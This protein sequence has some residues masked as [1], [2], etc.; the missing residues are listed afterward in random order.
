MFAVLCITLAIKQ[1]QPLNKI[2]RITGDGSYQNVEFE[3][4]G[5]RIELNLT[6]YPFDPVVLIM[7][8]E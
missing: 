2:S 8:I 5:D 3:R 1:K 6:A 4:T 7:N